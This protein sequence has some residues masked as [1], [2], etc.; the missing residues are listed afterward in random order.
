MKKYTHEAA[1]ALL[2]NK[3]AELEKSRYPRRS[4][5][6]DAEVVAIKALL[7]PWPR[8]LE[9]AEIKPI[10]DDRRKAKNLE[11]RIRAKRRRHEKQ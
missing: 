1:I 8:A 3:Y 9:A 10:R 7:G 4:D 2:K 11:K 6:S 5:F